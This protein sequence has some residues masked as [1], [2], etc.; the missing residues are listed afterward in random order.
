MLIEVTEEDIES[1]VR[2]DCERCPVAKAVWR[3]FKPDFVSVDQEYIRVD[4]KRWKTPEAVIEFINLFDSA[5]PRD[6]ESYK[7]LPFSFELLDA[8]R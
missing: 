8:P 1:G 5:D 4:E 7:P 3:A 2:D 6:E